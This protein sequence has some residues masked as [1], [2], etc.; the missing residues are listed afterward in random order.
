VQL[1]VNRADNPVAEL[2]V[3]QRFQGGAVDLNHL[4]EAVDGRISG[5]TGQAAAQRDD[6]KAGHRIGVQFEF[7]ANHF[8]CAGGQRMLAEQGCGDVGEAKAGA[9]SQILP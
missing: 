2:L 9:V 1:E 5:H 7:V 4:V 8:C 6:L 3:Y